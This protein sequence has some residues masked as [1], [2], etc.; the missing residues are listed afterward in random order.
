MSSDFGGGFDTPRAPMMSQG[1]EDSVDESKMPDLSIVDTGASGR[2]YPRG[3]A[4]RGDVTH[5]VTH[6]QRINDDTQDW[7]SIVLNQVLADVLDKDWVDASATND[8]T[9]F[10]ITNGMDDVRLLLTMSEDD[11]Q[12]MGYDINFK[13][14]CALQTI[15][16]MYNKQILDSMSEYDENMWFLNLNKRVVMRHMMRDTKVT[17][18][19]SASISN[20]PNVPL[21]RSNSNEAKLEMARRSSLAM[22][23]VGKP[24]LAPTPMANTGTR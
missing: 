6:I 17:T 8:F 21:G 3:D 2:N 13:T 7:D 18:I 19:P 10:V 22:F 11:Y 23:N 24:L 4:S 9:V 12:L 1:D 15:N 20:M 16:K 5:A 14:F